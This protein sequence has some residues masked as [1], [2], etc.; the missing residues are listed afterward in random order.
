MIAYLSFVERRYI[1]LFVIH[2]ENLETLKQYIVKG[3]I[4]EAVESGKRGQLRRGSYQFLPNTEILLSDS[5]LAY[6]PKV[7]DRFWVRGINKS[8]LYTTKGL[9]FKYLINNKEITQKD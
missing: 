9:Y 4:R 7:Q 2:N 1:P 5:N 3:R 8:G 6:N